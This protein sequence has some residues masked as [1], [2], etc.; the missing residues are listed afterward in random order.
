MLTLPSERHIKTAMIVILINLMT[1][2]IRLVHGMNGSLFVWFLVNS[3]LMI[4]KK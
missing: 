1:M 4:V 2:L 3:S